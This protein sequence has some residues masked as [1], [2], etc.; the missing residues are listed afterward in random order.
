MPGHYPKSNSN[1]AVNYRSDS[2]FHAAPIVQ[3]SLHHHP[4]SMQAQ[5]VSTH[6]TGPN[7]DPGYPEDTP[8]N[9]NGG[10]ARVGRRLSQRQLEKAPEGRTSRHID[11]DDAAAGGM[12]TDEELPSAAHARIQSA[13]RVRS[14]S[15]TPPPLHP[16]QQVNRQAQGPVRYNSPPP[17]HPAS[18]LKKPSPP[19]TVAPTE[20]PAE[21]AK[22]VETHDYAQPEA[23]TETN[24]PVEDEEDTDDM[25]A[26]AE[27]AGG[28]VNAEAAAP[29]T[30]TASPGKSGG[31]GFIGGLLGSLRGRGTAGDDK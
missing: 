1:D 20:A 7:V 30:T 5:P 31:S 6:T 9:Q 14:T 25:Y 15:I 28:P 16:A 10:G 11:D 23:A 27:D 29:D 19:P 21:P 2:S 18:A 26:A 8:V 13:S 3:P 17:V 24:A 22:G 12:S 4:A